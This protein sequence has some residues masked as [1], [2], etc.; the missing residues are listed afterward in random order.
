MIRTIMV[1]LLATTSFAANA[2]ATPAATADTTQYGTVTVSKDSRID[3]LGQK[4]YDYNV[5]LAKNIRSGK[6]YRLML[7]STND[8]NLAMNLRAKLLQMYP[9][10][11]VYM[12]Y[13]NPF[14]KLKMGNFED[15][16]DAEKLRK[17]LLAQKLTPGNIYVVP[18]TIEIKPPSEDEEDE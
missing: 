14:I 11:K 3:L 2:Q 15:K 9:E 1:C 17:T 16:N 10:H 4:M 6:G 12:T 13:Q 5:A 18:E 8:R 7:I